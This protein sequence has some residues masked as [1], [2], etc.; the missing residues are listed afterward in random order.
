MA[1]ESLRDELMSIPGVEAAE[2]DGSSATPE[3]VKV[4]LAAGVDVEA[5]GE[6]IQRV[7]TEHGLRSELVLD[8]PLGR[9]DVATEN[10]ALVRGAVDVEGRGLR[11][12]H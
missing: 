3:G 11:F 5:V 7:L 10:I 4:R 2:F 1:A 8:E 6:E 9:D 12:A